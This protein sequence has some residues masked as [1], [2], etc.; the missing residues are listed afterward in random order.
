MLYFIGVMMS[1]K[2]LQKIYYESI[3]NYL[4][5]YTARL[6]SPDTI[7]LPFKVSHSSVFF[8]QNAEIAD[9]VFKILKADKNI[10]LLCSKLPGVAIDQFKK[11]CLIDEII[12]TNK[13]EGVYSTRREIATILSELESKVKEKRIKRRFRGLV[14]QYLKLL[15]NE[16]ILI[17]TCKDIRELYDELVLAEVVEEE[18][19]NAPDGELFRKD[20]TSVY[21]ATDKEIHRGIYPESE[22]YRKLEEALIFLND[23]DIYFL[24]RIAVFHFLF[25]HIHPFYDGN[26]RLGRF[27]VSATL[28]RE[29]NPLLAYRISYTI[30][31]NINDYYKAFEIC[32][33]PRNLGDLTP[34]LLMMLNMIKT[35]TIQL[36][37]ALNKRHTQFI[38]YTDCINKLPGGTN[39]RTY[40]LYQLLIQGGLFSENGISTKVL[41]FYMENSYTTVK[42]ELDIIEKNQLLV[43][44]RVGRDNLY[45]LNLDR[46]DTFIIDIDKSIQTTIAGF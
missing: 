35:S 23:G 30:A 17:T 42:K 15:S 11:R 37:E 20:S 39:S 46:M 34:F 25:G 9:L 12:L 18:P 40:K 44:T 13:I 8:V 1:Y 38:H 29:L 10:S 32:N 31:E 4:N 45:M 3:D 33:N 24:Y 14:E 22:I 26:G 2:E 43:K 28:A 16:E 19:G 27:I 6:D 5:E 41:E 21:S 7:K 36:E